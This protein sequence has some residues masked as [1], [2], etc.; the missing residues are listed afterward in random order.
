MPPNSMPLP[1]RAVMC[2]PSRSSSSVR[3]SAVG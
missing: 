3:G 1:M 2:V